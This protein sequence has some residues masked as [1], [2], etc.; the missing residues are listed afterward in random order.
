MNEDF[1]FTFTLVCEFRDCK[2]EA[3]YEGWHRVLDFANQPTGMIQ[4][5]CVCRDCV[6]YLIGHDK[7]TLEE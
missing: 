5:M 7:S 1:E 4:K 3:E 6:K 2:N